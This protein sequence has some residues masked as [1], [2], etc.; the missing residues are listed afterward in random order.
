MIH[1][2][3]YGQ[4]LLDRVEQLLWAEQDAA[5]TAAGWQVIKV[6]RWSRTY[7]HPAVVAARAR[8]YAVRT[9]ERAA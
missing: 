3:S 4:R 1:G 2:A 5:K 9:P 8:R 6:G 7:R